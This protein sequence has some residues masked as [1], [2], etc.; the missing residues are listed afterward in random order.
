VDAAGRFLYVPLIGSDRTL[1]FAID[2]TGALTLSSSVHVGSAPTDTALQIGSRPVNLGPR[3]VYVADGDSS[4]IAGFSM[5]ASTGALTAVSGAAPSLAT[6]T[7]LGSDGLGRYVF[8]GASLV[9]S[10]RI[11]GSGQLQE[12]GT[13]FGAASVSMTVDPSAEMVMIASSGV[14]ISNYG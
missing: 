11:G 6:V 7:S 12:V 3:Y 4:T 8:A 1:V 10:Y 5:N 9:H 14:G 2:S 13:G